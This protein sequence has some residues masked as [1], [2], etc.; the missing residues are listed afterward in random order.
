MNQMGE[1]L[2][3]EK[4]VFL[5]LEPKVDHRFC[6]C[7]TKCVSLVVE[8]SSS[9]VLFGLPTAFPCGL[10]CIVGIDRDPPMCLDALGGIKAK[11]QPF[12]G[13]C[14]LEVMW[15]W[16]WSERCVVVNILSDVGTENTYTPA[17][18]EALSRHH[19]YHPRFE[20][21]ISLRATAFSMFRE[22]ICSVVLRELLD[23][24]V[25]PLNCANPV[26]PG[27]CT[28]LAHPNVR[29]NNYWPNGHS[30]KF[31][32][33]PTDISE[34]CPDVLHHVVTSKGWKPEFQC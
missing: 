9:V 13:W 34:I 31:G 19:S 25:E 28:S 4:R 10:R 1:I 22:E 16:T 14:C 5:R 26:Q 8:S 27:R 11:R 18:L 29:A 7:S 23:V 30:S 3:G 21:R 6:K 20:V 2:C 12:C 24:C 32:R 17:R 33:G 15:S